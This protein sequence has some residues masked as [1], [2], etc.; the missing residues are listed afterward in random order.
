MISKRSFRLV[1]TIDEDRQIGLGSKQS[2]VIFTEV[3]RLAGTI[4]LLSIIYLHPNLRTAPTIGVYLAPD[5]T[6]AAQAGSKPP[7]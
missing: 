4:L 3:L 2:E 1:G 7:P 5:R 6:E